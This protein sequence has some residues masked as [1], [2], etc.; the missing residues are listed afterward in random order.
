VVHDGL[1]AQSAIVYWNNGQGHFMF[2]Q[3]LG[4]ASCY[5]TL[6]DLEGDGDLDAYVAPWRIRLYENDGTGRFVDLTSGLPDFPYRSLAVGDVDGDGYADLI[7]ADDPVQSNGRTWVFRQYKNDGT[8]RF[9]PT[10]LSTMPD[11]PGL[12][13]SILQLIDL[14]DDG[15]LDLSMMPDRFN[16]FWQ[17]R[18]YWNLSRHVYAQAPPKPGAPYTV[19]FHAA[20]G[21]FVFPAASFGVRRQP[22]GPLGSLGLDP[23]SFVAGLPLVIPASGVASLT[24]PV[25]SNPAL[26]GAEIF[27]QGLDFDPGTGKARLTNVFPDRFVP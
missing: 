15:D 4:I 1:A 9:V 17:A 8:N 3:D 22:L 5:G 2:G 14:D 20:P 16:S 7:T 23:A 13:V 26:V 11:T 19:D 6:L 27:W 10:P 18:I 25:P 24:L 12:L 21:H